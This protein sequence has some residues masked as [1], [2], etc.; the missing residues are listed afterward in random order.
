MMFYLMI[1]SADVP[2]KK[3]VAGRKIDRGMH[4]MNGPFVFDITLSVGHRVVGAF[5]GMRQLKNDGERKTR[6]EVHQGKPDQHM[7]HGYSG[8]IR[9]AD[10][11]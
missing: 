11:Q 8:P 2:V 9:N 6:N 5:N 3:T 1:Q 10:K 7:Q 4:L